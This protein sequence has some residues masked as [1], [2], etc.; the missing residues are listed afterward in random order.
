MIMLG[1]ITLRT[2]SWG[3]NICDEDPQ[4]QTSLASHGVN[5]FAYCLHLPFLMS[6]PFMTF[7]DWHKDLEAPYKPMTTSRLIKAMLQAVRFSF[8][9]I[10]LYWISY[11]FF[12]HAF[13]Y[14]PHLIENLDASSVIGLMFF[15]RMQFQIK[16]VV[17]Y[18]VAAAFASLEGFTAPH[19]PECVLLMDRSSALWRRF[20]PGVYS[21]IVQCIY[22]PLIQS[23]GGGVWSRA[24][25]S[26]CVFVYVFT[27][28]GCTWP[29]FIWSSINFLLEVGEKTCAW[30]SRQDSYIL[31]E[32]RLLS[33]QMR[34]RFYA[35]V[36][37][38]QLAVVYFSMSI[39]IASHEISLMMIKVLFVN[40]KIITILS[41]IVGLY[42][43]CQICFEAYN[44]KLHKKQK[45]MK[46]A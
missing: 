9:S 36:V 6:G 39:F 2:L 22:K 20:D 8:W 26:L 24:F 38:L 19:P 18:G 21:F 10:V 12:G 16:Y 23:Y 45:S 46:S 42:C 31:W 15:H 29:I 7:S 35:L 32:E 14:S 28:H 37:A 11:T 3:Q 30:M 13:T 25:A 17:F 43:H 33:P 5:L 34:R 1:W 27:W 40:G 4:R 44:W 41:Y